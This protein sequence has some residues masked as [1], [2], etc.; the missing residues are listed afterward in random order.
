[1]I[2]EVP[3]AE[4]RSATVAERLT[5]RTQHPTG[6]VHGTT[7][8]LESSNATFI[9]DACT[10]APLSSRASSDRDGDCSSDRGMRRRLAADKNRPK[11]SKMLV[12]QPATKDSCGA[13]M[14][15]EAS[16]DSAANVT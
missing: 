4:L 10:V 2:G 7:K 6:Y 9:D 1:V 13:M 12:L 15:T 5:L 11:R 8:S 14:A 16:H 3:L